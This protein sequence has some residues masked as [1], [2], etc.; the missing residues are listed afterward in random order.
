M[1]SCEVARAHWVLLPTHSPDPKRLYIAGVTYRQM[2]GFPKANRDTELLF[3]EGWKRNSYKRVRRLLCRFL[4]ADADRAIS[5]LILGRMGW[6]LD[7]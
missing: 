4:G 7:A 1:K 6:P 3:S 2:T 5:L